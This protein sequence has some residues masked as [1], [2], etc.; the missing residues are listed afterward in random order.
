[1]IPSDLVRIEI[2]GNSVRPRWMEV[3]DLNLEIA[4]S[5]IDSYTSCIGKR[6]EEL[7]SAIRF[8]EEFY[9]YKLVRG[10][11][12]IME[13]RSKFVSG[14]KVSPVIAR[15]AIFKV[16]KGKPAL[17]K[18]L[19]DSI[20]DEAAKILKLDKEDLIRSAWAD[21]EGMQILENVEKMQP[22]DL[23]KNYNTSLVQSLLTKSVNVNL[24]I[25]EGW[26]KLLNS[27]K[28]LGLMYVAEKRNIGV[29]LNI[30]GPLSLPKP[31]EKYSLSF[32]EMIYHVVNC[33]SWD[34]TAHI[35][36]STRRGSRKLRL[37]LGSKIH[38]GLL[39]KISNNSFKSSEED[40]GLINV[41][42][43]LKAL[44]WVVKK[45]DGPV[46]INRSIVVP[47]LILEKHNIRVYLEKLGYWTHDYIRKRTLSIRVPKGVKVLFLADESMVCSELHEEDS[48][49]TYKGHLQSSKLLNKLKFIE[50]ELLANMCINID[51]N[52]IDEAIPIDDLAKHNNVS[53]E[54]I[55]KFLRDNLPEDF[56]VC[57][58]LL[59]NKKLI[60]KIDYLIKNKHVK[61]LSDL[62][63]HI[64]NIQLNFIEIIIH[65][66]GYLVSW[67]G[68]TAD[69]AVIKQ[70]I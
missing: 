38:G 31:S 17:D 34:M 12:T 59:V 36:L 65:S 55:T 27:I 23:I 51:F 11:A 40:Q 15:E 43:D 5:V 50:N 53:K 54:V 25:S 24:R 58:N 64:P 39:A 19:R 49:V 57:S 21:I 68:I 45:V 62:H 14:A 3:N 32:A 61:T 47:E 1:M 22:F 48:I 69:D 33:K 9:D 56:I 8:I 44:G 13:K 7:D 52:K 46:T 30:L 60:N 41:E 2:K 4:R 18:E 42:K 37:E 63:R 20:I 26:G 35:I 10:L 6:K 66:L 16:S 28:K 67:E 70:K 29:W